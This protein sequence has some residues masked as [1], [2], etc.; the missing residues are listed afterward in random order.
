MRPDESDIH[1]VNGKLD[2]NDNAVV[3]PHQVEDIALIPDS[4]DRIESLPDIRKVLPLAV[5]DNIL[6]FLQ[7]G[8]GLRMLQDILAQ[9]LLGKYSHAQ[10]Y[11]ENSI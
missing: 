2:D 11:L 10:I 5:P 4:V 6:P 1:E 9:R 3:V 8:L 7:R